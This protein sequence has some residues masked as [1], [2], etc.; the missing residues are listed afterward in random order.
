MNEESFNIEYEKLNNE[1]KDAVDSIYWP[2]MVVAWPGTGK[3]QIIWL[4]TA[5]II[6]KTWVNPAN[7]L[8]TTFTEAGV[9][10]IRQRLL[11]FIWSVAYKVT[12]STIHSLSQDIIKTFPEKFLEYK[13]W[14]PIDEIEQIEIIKELLDSLIKEKKI[15]ELTNDYDKYFY[16][17]DITSKIS[18]LKWEWISISRFKASIKNQ[19]DIYREELNEIKPTLKKYEETKEKQKKHIIKLEELAIIFE[20]YNLFLR[21]NSKYDF[22]DMINFVLEKFETDENIKYYY[23]EKFQF[24]MLDEY[25]DTNNAQNT[26]INQI[27]SVSEEEPNIMVVWDDDQ[28]IYRFQ[29]ANIENMLEFSTHYK[30]TKF[31]VLENNYRSTGEILDLSSALIENNFERLSKKIKWINKK[32][33]SNSKLNNIPV[34]FKANSDIEEKSFVINKIK[35]LINPPVTSDITLN[36]WESK[37]EEIAIIVRWNREVEN[38]T[39][40]LQQNDINVE[41]KLKTDILK[42]DYIKFILNYLQIINNPYSNEKIL[43]DLMRSHVVW[44]NQVDILKVNRALYI[45]N[46]SRKIKRTIFDYLLKDIFLDDLELENKD[47]LINFRDNLLDL[48]SIL[49]EKSFT[50]FFNIF[51]EKT[52]LL[53]HIESHWSFDDIEDIFTLLNKI[54]DWNKIDK[55]FNIEKL[56]SKIE[57]YKTYSYPIARQILRKNK[58]GVQILT[59]HS[60]KWLEYKSVFIPWLY[61]WNWE[62]K[63]IIDK[64]KL[65]SGVASEWLQSLNFDQIE[66]DRRLFFVAITRAKENLYLSYPAWIWNKPLLQSS[67]IEEVK[68]FYNEVNIYNPPLSSLNSNGGSNN[69]EDIIKNELKTSFIKYDDLEFDYIKEFLETYKLSPSDLNVFL[70]NPI[71]FLNNIVFKYPFI[72]NVFTIF[73]K[74]YHRTLE[75]FYLKYKE[76]HK[77][78]KKSYL[79]WT[80]NLL[81]DKEILTFDD[82]IKLKEKAEKWL[83]GYYDLYAS[84]SMEP[85][86]LEYSF[87]R[88]NIIFEWIPLT[89]TIDKIETSPQ[90]FSKNLIP[91]F[92]FGGEGEKAFFKD[93]VVLIDYKTW[94]SKSLWEIKWLDRYWNKKEGEWKYF[95]QLLFYKLLCDL[96]DDFNS[97]FIVWALALDFVEWKDWNKSGVSSAYK[98]IEVDFTQD[99]YEDFKNELL[100]AREKI[101]DIEFWKNLLKKHP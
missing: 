21:K 35:E 78:P 80:F 28:S 55:E 62:S 39:L 73:G 12:V 33:V 98:Y 9:I 64:L 19:E 18:S 43:I 84:K 66:E 94:K 54:K 96:D 95:R 87:R 37:C 26:I 71:N 30:N 31:I 40:L 82:N 90:P 69:I 2:V 76:E 5:N 86:M 65:P 68:G 17:R 36:K 50:E 56:L 63:R 99:E 20:E 34:L 49:S 97:K 4:R 32:L 89:W 24:I 101:R 47:S 46:Y 23:A 41:S 83:S 14:I 72:D 59:A 74:V 81:L 77:L 13:A 25:Q 67:F 29:W 79:T 3:T 22:S 57:L 42:S 52:N 100:N 7:I 60:S 10:A 15:K 11:K 75:L 91:T 93:S 8:I 1:Q 48:W 88:K 44:L 61:T 38:W 45:Q 85:L 53:I 16:L 6:L 92:S 58:S 27:L 70:E 51:L